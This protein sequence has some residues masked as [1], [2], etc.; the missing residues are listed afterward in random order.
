MRKPCFCISPPVKLGFLDFLCRPA[1]SFSSSSFSFSFSSSSFHGSGPRRC[2][3]GPGKFVLLLRCKILFFFCDVKSASKLKLYFS[4]GS[5]KPILPSQRYLAFGKPFYPVN[6]T[7]PSANHFYLVN[8]T[9]P[10]AKT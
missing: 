3:A 9:W 2:P 5:G 6:D 8:D 1:S 7:W 10:S 4:L